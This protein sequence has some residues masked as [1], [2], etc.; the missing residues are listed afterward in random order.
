MRYLVFWLGTVLMTAVAASPLAAQAPPPAPIG[1][2]AAATT[3]P[4]PRAELGAFVTPLMAFGGDCCFAGVQGGV[5]VS[6]RWH[7]EGWVTLQRQSFEYTAFVEG[8]YA[9]Q[10]RWDIW[11]RPRW[12]GT[13]LFFSV[14]GV[15]WFSHIDVAPMVVVT[16]Q[17]DTWTTSAYSGTG[18]DPPLP[19]GGLGVIKPL[20]S[21]VALRGD[22][23]IHLGGDAFNVL[24]NVGVSFAIG[25]Y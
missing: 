18:Y 2:P 24:A 19:G 10:A 12:G 8:Y 5:R 13:R 22:V 4:P 9:G 6:R 15:G 20:G 25:R 1:P 23:M 7:L 16:P 17:G 21:R 3:H 11:E 14:G